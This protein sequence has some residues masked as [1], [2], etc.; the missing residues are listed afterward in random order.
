M[1]LTLRLVKGSALTYQEMD[2]N[3]QYLYTAS[4]NI[5]GSQL[6]TGSQNVTGSFNITGSIKA[7]GSF[8]LKGNDTSINTVTLYAE[9]S[10]G[11]Q[12]FVY[13]NAGRLILNYPNS[14]LDNTWGHTFSAPANS[15]SKAFTIGTTGLGSSLFEMYINGAFQIGYLS[16][17]S[18]QFSGDGTNKFTFI[19]NTYQKVG[20][21]IND[22]ESILHLKSDPTSSNYV[23]H[24]EKNDGTSLLS[25]YGSSL[26][27]LTG[28]LIT[29]GSMV[30]T[31]SIKL[32]PSSSF[33]LPIT[34]SF[35]APSTGSMFF[36]A[37]LLYI[38]DGTRYR[39]ASFV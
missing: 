31:G 30:V 35:I 13:N 19:G 32:S 36:S 7:T 21:N 15:V 25:V 29:T 26:V 5:T 14:G 34:A 10:D 37:S 2:N 4:L 12:N 18:H 8:S 17:P 1:S 20:I 16:G 33:T 6:I 3:L 22:P 11:S 38:Y 27:E 24:I 39:S 9:N 28:S 23:F